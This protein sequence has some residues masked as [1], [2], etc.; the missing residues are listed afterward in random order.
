MEEEYTDESLDIFFD[1]YGKAKNKEI[2][3]IFIDKLLMYEKNIVNLTN[4]GK[5]KLFHNLS[6]A[7][8]LDHIDGHDQDLPNA[9]LYDEK[10]EDIAKVINKDLTIEFYREYLYNRGQLYARIKA[11][12]KAEEIFSEYIYLKH[13][14]DRDGAISIDEKTICY[15]FHN[16]DIHVIRDFTTSSISLRDP[17]CFN[18][19]FDTLLFHFIDFHQK[20]ILKNADYDIQPFRDAYKHIKVGCF[21]RDKVDGNDENKRA[22]KNILMW[23][24]YANSHKGICIRYKLNSEAIKEFQP[25][26]TFTNLFGVE[27][28]EKV[29]FEEKS[30]DTTRKLFAT[31]QKNWDYENEVRIIH[32]DSLNN[33]EFI[34]ISLEKIKGKIEAIFFGYRCSD[35]DKELIKNLLADKG[36]EFFNF[37]TDP[38]K[39]YDDVY[40]LNLEDEERFARMEERSLAEN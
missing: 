20:K 37:I 25:N 13:K 31:K 24:H 7:L 29:G 9:I 6:L 3:V 21:A 40:N 8:S 12:K 11:N 30:P 15:G 18:D 36:I 38:E 14:Y 26:N 19:P 23:S 4:D 39:T 1:S 16:V 35:K 22:F 32:F 17:T 33:D 5:L 10:A 2:D 28:E 34:Q 27:Y